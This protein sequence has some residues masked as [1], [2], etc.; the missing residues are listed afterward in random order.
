[1]RPI[2]RLAALWLAPLVSLGAQRPAADSARRPPGGDSAGPAA[3]LPRVQVRAV[4]RRKPPLS[5]TGSDDRT[6]RAEAPAFELLDPLGQGRLGALLGASPEFVTGPGGRFSLMGGPGESNQLT[7]GG[8]RMPAG[9]VTGAM[10]AAI[11][12]SP[13]DVSNGGAAGATTTLTI[14]RGSRFRAS[15]L[16]LRTSA[17]GVPGAGPGNGAPPGVTLPLQLTAVTTGQW[18]TMRYNMNAFASRETANLRRWEGALT[19]GTRSILDSIAHLTATP[20]RRA[21]DVSG[22]YGVVARLDLPNAEPEQSQTRT[23]YLTA[24]VTRTSDVGGTRGLFS[25][26]STGVTAVQ[27]VAALLFDDHRLVRNTYR[28]VANAS[29]TTTTSRQHRASE[30]PAIQLSDGDLGAIIVTGGGPPQGATRLSAGDA[31]AQVTWFSADNRRRYLVQLQGRYEDMRV[32]ATPAQSAFVA[33][34][35]SALARG[36]ALTMTRTEATLARRASSLVAAPAASVGFDLGPR[37]SMLVGVR[38]DAW[39]ASGV[40]PTATRRG[41]DLLPRL[42]FQQRLGK[43]ARGNVAMA[44]LRGGAGRFVDWPSLQQWGPAWTSAGGDVSQCNGAAVPPVAISLAAP[45]CVG[46]DPVITRTGRPIAAASLR[47]VASTRGDLSLQ[48]HRLTRFLQAELG[49]AASRYDR[50]PVLESAWFGRPVEATLSGDGNRAT[51]VAPSRIGSDGVVPFAGVS[52]AE[53]LLASSGHSTGWQYRVRLSTRDLWVRSQLLANYTYNDGRATSATIAPAFGSPG[54]V[55]APATGS[56][57]TIMASL[58]SWVGMAQVRA[59]LIA[60]SG[61]RF[62]PVADRDL[63]GD[64]LANDAA[65]VPADRATTWAAQ[66]P[67]PMRHCVLAAA[68]RI[69]SPSACSGPWSVSSMLVAGLPGPQLGLPASTEIIFQLSNPTALLSRIAGGDRLSFGGAA[70]IDPR[71]VRI[72][73]YTPATQQFTTALLQGAGRPVG[74]AGNITEPMRVAISVR[75]PLGRSSFDRRIDAAVQ[76]LAADTSHAARAEAAGE[77]IAGLP[78]IPEL[79][80]TQVSHLELTRDQ[81]EQLQSLATKWSTITPAAIAGIRPRSGSDADARRRLLAARRDAYL[82]LVDLVRA[83]IRALTPAQI[84]TLEPFELSLLN[85]RLLRWVELSP[86]PL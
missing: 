1:M 46:A 70:F 26:A 29:A 20:L 17:A 49:V 74:L 32:G 66:L 78:N 2:G 31:R 56:R 84:A 72:T 7:L 4:R 86:Y 47:P 6:T 45:E 54:L 24:A 12:T 60:R 35:P 8:V 13:W 19:T 41:I 34:S 3:T 18:R 36:V 85:L 57:H 5:T 22:Q 83:T 37:G 58:G 25:T 27:D 68:G 16:L 39:A 82:Q 62:T 40:S 44:T 53:P 79:F 9:M 14:D 55:S 64:G 38:A 81:R 73:G 48:I 21:R 61:T 76:K 10:S 33:E 80:L 65:F 59:M 42:S 52:R 11:A 51:L 15:Y 75:I 23:S 71:L 67:A 50:I 63:N 28:V 43:G 30:A 77:V 69:V